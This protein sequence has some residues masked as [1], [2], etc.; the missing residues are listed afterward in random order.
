[1][2]LTL[3]HA[4]RGKRKTKT[5]DYLLFAWVQPFWIMP[6][7]IIN[8]YFSIVTTHKCIAKINIIFFNTNSSNQFNI[9][10]EG[11]QY[12]MTDILFIYSNINIRN[13][14]K[15][16]CQKKKMDIVFHNF[17]KNPW[18]VNHHGIRTHMLHVLRHNISIQLDIFYKKNINLW[19][20]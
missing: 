5:S 19:D 17:L 11:I 12:P 1:M 4:S 10:I 20:I 16:K 9:K 14:Y 7:C 2:Q 8:H 18:H 6:V 3:S 13:N 15:L